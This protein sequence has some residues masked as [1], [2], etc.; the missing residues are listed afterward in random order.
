MSTILPRILDF[1]DDPVLWGYHNNSIHK[2]IYRI[3][4]ELKKAGDI[5]CGHLIKKRDRNGNIKIVENGHVGL[6][7]RYDFGEGMEWA[8]VQSASAAAD[9]TLYKA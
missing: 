7:I 6:L 8:V 2:P 1:I 5:A 4:G 3:N 9:I